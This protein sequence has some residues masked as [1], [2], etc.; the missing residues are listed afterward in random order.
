ML[1][2]VFENSLRGGVFIPPNAPKKVQH[3]ACKGTAH[4][5][6]NYGGSNFQRTPSIKKKISQT[7]QIA[8]DKSKS[9][10]VSSEGA[11]ESD[12]FDSTT[13]GEKPKAAL[14]DNNPQK[15]H[16]TSR[17]FTNVTKASEAKTAKMRHLDIFD[18]DDVSSCW[19]NDL[20][21]NSKKNINDAKYK[22][23][24]DSLRKVLDDRLVLWDRRVG[25]RRSFRFK[26][27]GKIESVNYEDV[28]KEAAI[29][30]NAGFFRCLDNKACFKRLEAMVRVAQG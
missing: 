18:V 6:G 8:K 9:A 16:V 3:H 14:P 12:S 28:A 23:R 5:S 27:F 22:S 19:T 20:R 17:L 7:E 25:L 26:K 30:K 21:N 11:S 29:R 1:G 24:R 2:G 4:G 10:S 15:K 13:S